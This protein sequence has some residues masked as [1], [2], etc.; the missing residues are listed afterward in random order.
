M[1]RWEGGRRSSY[2]SGTR[3]VK[4]SGKY[5]VTEFAITGNRAHFDCGARTRSQP[6]VG[7]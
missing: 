2:F 4:I 5:D 7:S 3:Q 6:L 1:G